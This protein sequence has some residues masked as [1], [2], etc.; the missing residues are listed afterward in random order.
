MLSIG[1]CL[2][3]I[4]SQRGHGF[5]WLLVG[6]MA[7]GTNHHKLGDLRQQ[8]GIVWF[9]RRELQNHCTGRTILPMKSIESFL[10]LPALDL[11]PIL[12]LPWLACVCLHMAFSCLCLS[13]LLLRTP[14]ILGSGPTAVHH[15][16]MPTN[17]ILSDPIFIQ[18]HIWRHWELGL[19]YIF[20]GDTIQPITDCMHP[21]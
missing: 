12:G 1:W 6:G 16:L 7:V 4:Q 15:N 5:Q 21:S 11:V 8:T 10:P 14:V 13:P 2:K 18:G 20:L 9:W 3:Q 19:S 17:F